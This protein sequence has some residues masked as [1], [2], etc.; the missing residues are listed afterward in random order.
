M[1]CPLRTAGGHDAGGQL[2]WASRTFGGARLLEEAPKGL[3]RAKPSIF[4][5]IEPCCSFRLRRRAAPRRRPAPRWGPPGETYLYIFYS[6]HIRKCS[7]F[8]AYK[9]GKQRW[10]Y[11]EVNLVL[12]SAPGEVLEVRQV[13]AGARVHADGFTEGSLRAVAVSPVHVSCTLASLVPLE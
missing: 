5:V 2:R 1:E 6:P 12:Y 9:L 11:N 4:A 13:A 7:P 10:S 3:N 8:R